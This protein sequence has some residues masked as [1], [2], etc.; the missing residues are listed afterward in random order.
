[1]KA[2]Q[3]VLVVRGPASLSLL[4][5]SWPNENLAT[6]QETGGLMATAIEG[7]GRIHAVYCQA[8][9]IAQDETTFEIAWRGVSFGAS[10]QP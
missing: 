7:H 5:Q 2:C 8:T 10:L 1:M 3:A 4:A 9:G 6:G